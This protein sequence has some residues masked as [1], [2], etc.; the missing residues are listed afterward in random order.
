MQCRKCVYKHGTIVSSCFYLY[1]S[2][3]CIYGCLNLDIDSTMFVVNFILASV[4]S[5]N[6]IYKA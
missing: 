5:S 3:A 1:L 2:F 6:Y 4:T